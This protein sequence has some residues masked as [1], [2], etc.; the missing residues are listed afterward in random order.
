MVA[1]QNGGIPLPNLIGST[2]AVFAV[3]HEQRVRHWDRTAE[4]LLGY[5]PEDVLGRPCY[6][7]VAGT[8]GRSHPTCR[9]DCPTIQQLRRRRPVR[10]YLVLAKS[11]DGSR[12]W[13][14]VGTLGFHD[15]STSELFL[16]H[17]LR[18]PCYADA[19]RIRDA[20]E[21]VAAVANL[22]DGPQASAS[23]TP[24]VR[25]LTPR[26]VEVLRLLAAGYTTTQIASVLVL[27]PTTVR[28]HIQN[29]LG[30]LQARNRLQ[31]IAYAS[32]QNLL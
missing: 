12:R 11:K 18:V 21:T 22:P 13:L 2:D 10:D 15:P 17:L 19:H 30:K 32:R 26:E 27:Q 3:D 1:R 31:A 14:S 25:P 4:E 8:D 7:V 9:K 24:P 23:P 6:D 16:V 28:N 20:A 5:R 29:I